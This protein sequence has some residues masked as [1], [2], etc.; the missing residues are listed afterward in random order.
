LVICKSVW[1]LAAIGVVSVAVLFAKF[2]SAPL[3]AP[4]AIET[5]STI[6]V[7][8]PG[9]GEATFTAKVTVPLTPAAK[10]PMESVNRP[11]P[12]SCQAPKL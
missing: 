7:T 3:S 5:V 9:S 12:S 6:C 4:S 8:P 2:R 11:P 1:E 10:S